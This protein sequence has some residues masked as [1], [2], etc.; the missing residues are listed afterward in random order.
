MLDNMFSY[1]EIFSD[2]E[3][4]IPELLYGR[5]DALRKLVDL[6]SKQDLTLF[7]IK[8]PRRS[9][10]SSLLL[11]LLKILSNGEYK[12]KFN[13]KDNWI[14]I[15]VK[16]DA[17]TSPLSLSNLLLRR[18][19]TNYT[20]KRLN[21][22]KIPTYAKVFSEKIEEQLTVG[23]ALGGGISLGNI[24]AS[25]SK[26]K[27]FA[28]PYSIDLS[29]VSDI[30]YESAEG[31]KIIIM[32]DELQYIYENWKDNKSIFLQFLKKI[33]D[34]YY[35]RIKVVMTGSVI[36]PA[37][38]LLSKDY[39]E[40]LHGRHI[41]EYNIGEISFDDAEKMLIDGFTS[42][43]VNYNDY[44]LSSALNLTFRIPGWLA[45]FGKYYV[46]T[47]KLLEAIN[48][49]YEEMGSLVREE[50]GKLKRI[51]KR[52]YYDT[53]VNMLAKKGI[54]TPLELSKQLNISAHE[55]EI[56]LNN[57]NYI[58]FINEKGELKD[59]TIASL[60]NDFEEMICPICNSGRAL[61]LKGLHYFV[62]FSCKHVVKL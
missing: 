33:S 19:L 26:G 6:V 7:F 18:G 5:E 60:R 10:K 45:Y 11:T 4:F 44:I 53:A 16:L 15:M 23:R 14:P 39:T 52:E 54:L 9:G 38:L 1:T 50:L 30:L 3:R 13:V 59:Y 57:L 62:R 32:F 41:E 2:K 22:K 20:L 25:V 42:A 8:G 49:S 58:D 47:G 51:K 29:L 56:I 28:F 37:E 12:Q 43:N 46:E 48:K 27:N 35:D 31:S 24:G 21:V 61:V 17:V 55:A 36:R 40:E 34:E